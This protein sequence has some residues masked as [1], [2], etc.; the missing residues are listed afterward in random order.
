MN[1][2]R[3]LSVAALSLSLG[4][5]LALPGAALARGKSEE[6]KNVTIDLNTKAS[7]NQ[8]KKGVKMAV[9][10]RKWEISNE[11]GNHFEASYTKKE[12]RGDMTA[13]IHVS[14]TPKQ[15]KITYA[16]SENMNADGTSI[17]PWYNKWVT[18]LEK[19]IPIYIEREVVAS[20]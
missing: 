12:R 6:I 19:D 13:R 2:V 1:L 8:I 11:K 5:G 18:N 10:N 3:A 17:H 14:Y 16:G 9:L 20:E 15:V 7:A 4:L